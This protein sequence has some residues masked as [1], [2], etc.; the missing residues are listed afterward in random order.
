LFFPVV[1]V[2]AFVAAASAALAEEVREL[3]CVTCL[4]VA[5]SGEVEV[6]DLV[7]SQPA[8]KAMAAAIA[9]I[10]ISFLFIGFL[11]CEGAKKTPA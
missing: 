11:L 1:D 2:L 9:P 6:E 7:V 4:L 8:R 10:R 3:S 5:G